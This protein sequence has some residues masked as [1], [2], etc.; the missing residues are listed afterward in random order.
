MKWKMAT[1]T[2]NGVPKREYLVLWKLEKELY[3]EWKTNPS[4]TDAHNRLHGAM[5]VVAM[6]QGDAPRLDLIT[7]EN[8]Y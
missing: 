8:N 2:Y 1:R 4:D 7:P 5:N 3:D 6:C